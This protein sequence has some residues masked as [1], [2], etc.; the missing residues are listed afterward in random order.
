MCV[1]VFLPLLHIVNKVSEMGGSLGS[2]LMHW[3]IETKHLCL[4]VICWSAKVTCQQ[5][6]TGI[7]KD[8]LWEILYL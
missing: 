4:T 7:F 2:G 5:R 6:E 8:L 1:C 3:N